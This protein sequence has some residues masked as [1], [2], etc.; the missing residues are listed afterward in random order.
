MLG[1]FS[2]FAFCKGFFV[3]RD[4]INLADLKPYRPGGVMIN[5][6]GCK[7]AEEQEAKLDRRRKAWEIGLGRNVGKH[8]E[9]GKKKGWVYECDTDIRDTDYWKYAQNIIL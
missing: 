7:P 9:A 8:F 3:Y 5:Y 4:G 1:R 2:A 6:G